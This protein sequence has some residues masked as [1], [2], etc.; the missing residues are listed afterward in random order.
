[1][2]ENKCVLLHT[3]TFSKILPEQVCIPHIVHRPQQISFSNIVHWLNILAHC[4]FRLNVSW[5]TSLSW[6][7]NRTLLVTLTTLSLGVHESKNQNPIWGRRW[8]CCGRCTRPALPCWSHLGR[9]VQ[10][11]HWWMCLVPTDQTSHWVWGNLWRLVFPSTTLHIRPAV[12]AGW[13]WW[14]IQNH[15]E[16]RGEEESNNLQSR[17]SRWKKAVLPSIDHQEGE[18]Q[19]EEEAPMKFLCDVS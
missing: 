9:H 13:G 7:N 11:A 1:M 2:G 17:R 6:G 10:W 4:L 12:A 14:R 5:Q 3:P 19:A 16:S 18:D 15:S 8:L